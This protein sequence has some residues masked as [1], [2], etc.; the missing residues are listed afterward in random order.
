[1]FRSKVTRINY[2][3]N[4]AITE[5]NMAHEEELLKALEKK[6]ITGIEKQPDKNNNY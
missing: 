4:M 3:L 6:I 5:L 1:M 2:T